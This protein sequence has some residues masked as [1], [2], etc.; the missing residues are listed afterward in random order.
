MNYWWVNHRQTF[1]QE[2]G[3]GYMW[4][5]K[6][7]KNGGKSHFY[8]NMTRVKA[9]DIVYSFAYGQIQAVGVVMSGASSYRK[10]E[11][12]G[13]TG[14]NWE[15]EGWYVPVKFE[16]YGKP[17]RPKDKM[18]VIAPL[19]PAKY[20][21]IQANGNGNQAAY[22]SLVSKQLASNLNALIGLVRP[23][24]MG[25]D[26]THINLHKTFSTPHGGGGPGSGPIAVVNKLVE[27]LSST[28]VES[29]EKF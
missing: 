16:R 22:L 21:P 19:L 26:I 17:F 20:S 29:K 9:G 8:D 14:D 23:F 5:P 11:E 4:S 27:F 13:K 6:T 3:G 24:D 12:F 28:V 18:D 10:P 2:F 15:N 1:K 7:N 25:F